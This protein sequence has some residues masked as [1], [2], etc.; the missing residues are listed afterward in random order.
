MLHLIPPPVHR[1][2]Y[3][4]AHALRCLY[5]RAWKPVFDGCRIVAIDGEGRVLL[6]RHSYGSGEWMPPSGGMPRGEDSVKTA[7][8]ELQEETGCMLEG[9]V[10]LAV[11]EEKLHG[12][13]NRVHVIAG[14]ASGDPRP[15]NREVVDAAFFALDAL[16]ERMPVGLRRQLPDWVRAFGS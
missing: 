10:E 5:W 3:R 6:I 15:D 1:A 8:R 2:L 7:I 16:P 9:A 14:R 12:A 13:T 11:L 4:L